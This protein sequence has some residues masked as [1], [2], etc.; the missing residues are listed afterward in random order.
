MQWNIDRVNFEIHIQIF[1]VK[2]ARA[3]VIKVGETIPQN[4]VGPC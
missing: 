2:K 1:I 4:S 3:Y